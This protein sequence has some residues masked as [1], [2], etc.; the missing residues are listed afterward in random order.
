MSRYSLDLGALIITTRE[1]NIGVDLCAAPGGVEWHHTGHGSPVPRVS[2]CQSAKSV[3]V[4]VSDVSGNDV[5][6]RFDMV[7]D[8]AY[9]CLG[10]E[11]VADHSY[12]GEVWELDAECA[13]GDHAARKCRTRSARAGVRPDCVGVDTGPS[14][15]RA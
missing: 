7:C 15:V 5:F 2:R 4:F 14:G 11:P 8:K 13:Y 6:L 1:P 10:D 3:D 12:S 9:P